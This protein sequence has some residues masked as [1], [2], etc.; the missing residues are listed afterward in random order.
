M[1]IR[2]R[3]VRAGARPVDN[4]SRPQPA[5]GRG[6][7]GAIDTAPAVMNEENPCT[8]RRRFLRLHFRHGGSRAADCDG[9]GPDVDIELNFG[10]PPPVYEVV[11]APRA[12]Y[13]WAPGYWDYER[14]R[15]IWRKGHWEHS[16]TASAG[17]A[18]SGPSVKASGT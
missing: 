8:R 17:P 9:A 14:N 2:L 11:P 3:P 1:E 13:I 15:H 10:P 7:S 12:G 4:S 18:A 5:T 6:V 16:G